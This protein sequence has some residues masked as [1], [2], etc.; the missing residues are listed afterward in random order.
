MTPTLSQAV[1]W[2]AALCCVGA[3][4]AILRSALSGRTPGAPR[5]DGVSSR[6]RGE[7]AWAILPALGLA[8]VLVLTWR[9]V[10]QPRDRPAEAAFG[11]AAD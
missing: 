9:A 2:L 1:F 11:L 3:E 4:V 5:A 8:L 10:Q 7:L 6:R